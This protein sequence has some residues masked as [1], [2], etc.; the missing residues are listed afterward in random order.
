V[1]LVE[2]IHTPV[3]IVLPGRRNNPPEEN[4]RS[5][6]CY[7]PIH[8]MELPELFM[9]FIC[10]MTGKSPS[11][12]GAGSEG[13]LTKSP[14]N[15]LPPIMDLNNALVS[16]ILTGQHA[17]VTAAG[18][19]GPKAR[20]DHDVSLIVPEIFCRMSPEE[21]DPKFL[22]ANHYLEKLE[23]FEHGGKPILASRLG[24]RINIRFV[25]A[26]FGRV[27]NHPH[28]VFTEEML[29]PELQD[30]EIFADGMNN[31]V[32]TQKRVAKMYFD[33]GSLAQ[34]CPPLQALLHIMLNDEWDGKSLDDP[35]VRKLFTRENLLVSDWYAARLTAKQKVDRVLWKRHVEYLNGFLRKPS[36][37]DVAENLKIAGR[38][39]LARKT[40]EET[41]SP[42]YL[43][44][45][46][47]TP[48]AEPVENYL[49]PAG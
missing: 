43:K 32:A 8:Y 11:T 15:A 44:K 47:D 9:E 3:N 48:G 34:A 33:D 12:T 19:V 10:S 24:H 5:L 18:Y 30:L 7:N 49:P 28:A 29:K 37:E 27:F 25:H 23:D 17:F 36:H 42:D 45:L 38:L 21:S 39:T 14:F 20:V 35:G 40:L 2:P 16:F 13:A 26:F 46:R 22:I 41:E 4:I 1:P 6:A 31:I